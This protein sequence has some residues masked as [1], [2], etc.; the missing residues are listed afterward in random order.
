MAK[1]SEKEQ[2]QEEIRLLN[3]KVN[4]IKAQNEHYAKD[5]ED[6]VAQK[7][8]YE[9]KIETVKAEFKELDDAKKVS[10]KE[11]NE[12]EKKLSK[13]KKD[14]NELNEKF[15]KKKE[16]VRLLEAENIKLERRKEEL[17]YKLNELDKRI[18]VSQREVDT[19][20][21]TLKGFE[22]QLLIREGLLNKREETLDLKEKGV[23][24]KQ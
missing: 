3:L 14:Y 9:S 6:L 15:S 4:D 1:K 24:V 22:E 17:T 12:F 19:K 5:T 20:F 21:A 16:A 13:L 18:S 11:F 8:E 10:E 23:V 2:L 7:S